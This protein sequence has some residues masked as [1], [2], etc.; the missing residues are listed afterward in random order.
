MSIL[1]ENPTGIKSHDLNH[2]LSN[3]IGFSFSRKDLNCN[4]ELELIKKYIQPQ[5]DIE[6]I[7]GSVFPIDADE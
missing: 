1:R 3:K 5:F 7:Y 6:L 4:S 2:L